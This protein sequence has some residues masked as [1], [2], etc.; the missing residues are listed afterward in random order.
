MHL[1]PELRPPPS[2]YLAGLRPP[3]LREP[4]HKPT[5]LPP[6]KAGEKGGVSYAHRGCFHTGGL[7]VRVAPAGGDEGFCVMSVTRCPAGP[8]PI[9]PPVTPRQGQARPHRPQTAWW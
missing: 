8:R 1:S 2:P 6:A 4:V 5:E 7:A 3:A 9:T